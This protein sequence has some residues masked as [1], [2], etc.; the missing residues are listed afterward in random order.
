AGDDLGAPAQRLAPH[1]EHRVG[2]EE[3][4]PL[5]EPPR[6]EELRV[7]RDQAA[8]RLVRGRVEHRRAAYTTRGRLRAEPREAWEATMRPSDILLTDRV[9]IVTGGGQGIGEGI[10]LGFARF[11]AHVVIA[12]KNA[13][14][15]ERTAAS[16]R[17]LGR[18]GLAI[19]TDVREFDQVNALVDRTMEEF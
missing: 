8:D 12:D 14:T 19:T 10:A 15:G 13:E 18:R 11:G 1:L 4:A 16:V 7:D 2:G 6:V 17:A 5:V 3:L 9:A